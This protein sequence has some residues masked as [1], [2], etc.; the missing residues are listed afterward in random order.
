MEAKGACLLKLRL[1]VFTQC[2][3]HTASSAPAAMPAVEDID[4]DTSVKADA[5]VAYLA[6]GATAENKGPID[7]VFSPELGLAVEPLKPGYTLESLWKV[8]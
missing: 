2:E 6:D 8:L 1:I 3:L 4:V 5:C 7:P